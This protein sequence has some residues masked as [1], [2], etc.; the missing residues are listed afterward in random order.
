MRSK[1]LRFSK[2]N[3][4]YEAIDPQ[5]ARYPKS[6]GRE[7]TG[8]SN[9][10]YAAGDSANDR[11]GYFPEA[12]ADLEKLRI[13]LSENGW[14]EM[15][16]KNNDE[17]GN[18]TFPEWK[19]RKQCSSWLNKLTDFQQEEWQN[20]VVANAKSL[21][22]KSPEGYSVYVSV[23]DSYDDWSTGGKDAISVRLCNYG[24]FMSCASEPLYFNRTRFNNW[25][26]LIKE[27]KRILNVK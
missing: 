9:W 16:D 18:T 12:A 5:V 27:I 4:L 19:E 14:K 11:S 2:W 24:K 3:R 23:W 15:P 8:V 25:D 1:V 21:S 10:G 6:P 13:M 22:M 26:I 7:I 20:L 17:Y